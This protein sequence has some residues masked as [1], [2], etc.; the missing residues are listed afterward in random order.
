MKKNKIIISAF[1]VVSLVLSGFAGIVG[2]NASV[3]PSEVVATLAVG[4]SMTVEKTVTTPEIPPKIDV[5]LLEDET[6]SFWDDIGN[7]QGGTTASD[8][9]DN[10]VVKSPDAHFAV[11]GFRDYPVYPYGDPGDWVYSLNSG[12][13]PVKANWIAGIAALTA[14]GGADIPEAQYDAIVAAVAGCGWRS[15]STTRVLVVATDA[16]F[17]LPG[18]G[19]PHINTSATTITALGTLGIKVIGLKA[20][21]AG[22][23]LNTLATAT[24]GSVQAL[25][26]SGDNIATAILAGLGN[27]PITVTPVPVGCDPLVV[28]F[29]PTSQT[30]TSGGSAN[31]DETIA[32]PNGPT[33]AGSSVQCTVEFRDENGNVLEEGKQEISIEIPIA[34]DLNPKTAVNELGTPEQTHT[35]IA[36]VTSDSASSSAAISGALVSFEV[37]DGPN[38]GKSGSETTDS[39]GD[40]EFT[41]EAEQG[42]AGLGIDIIKACVFGKD[43]RKVCDK[44]TKEWKDTTPPEVSCVETVNP[45][46]KN[47]PPAGSIPPPGSKN[48]QNEDGFYQL[49]GEDAVDP[50]IKVCVVDEGSGMELGC[51]NSGTNVKYTEIANNLSTDP[52]AEPWVK[53]WGNPKSLVEWH[54]FGTGD[55]IIYATDSSGNESARVSC[56][57][58]PWP[59]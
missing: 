44:A 2:S 52:L 12:M 14:G 49:V 6:G 46:G 47:I 9:Y 35:V 24:G 10:V 39:A 55:M 48:G 59:K 42:I 3:S 16:P 40:A 1:S 19:K 53:P 56:L 31:F 54:I 34:I 45:S 33:L 36:S 32:V 8:I 26:S 30:V 5:C 29:N 38:A 4:E 22:N 20:L 43:G 15:D 25:S 41:Y 37:V 11:A 51:Y 58:P 7:L 23:E 21:G 17:H 57:V 18:V 13:S 28:T 27:L 50:D